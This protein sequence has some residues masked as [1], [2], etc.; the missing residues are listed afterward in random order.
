MNQ[1]AE[2]EALDESLDLER[3]VRGLPTV[4]KSAIDKILVDEKANRNSAP[5]KC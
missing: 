5:P 1:S 3:L 2:S 4:P